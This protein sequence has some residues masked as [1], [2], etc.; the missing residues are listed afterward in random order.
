MHKP[1]LLAILDGSSEI[2]GP[3][4]VGTLAICIVFFPVVLLYGVARFLFTR[5]TLAVVYAMLTSYLLSRTLVPAMSRYLMP[6]SHEEHAGSGRWAHFVRGFDRGFERFKDRYRY[7]LG[8][9]IARR[10]FGLTCVMILVASSLFLVPVV[11]EDFFP[12]VDAGMMKMHVR[13][14]SGTRVEETEHIVDNIDKAIRNVIPAN[15]LDQISDN[16]GMPPFAYVL[17]F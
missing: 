13:A 15:E 1:L 11:G 12:A 6:S 8:R 7:T 17:A 9:F 2:A 16:I 14:P 5:L 4:F 10:A 3:A